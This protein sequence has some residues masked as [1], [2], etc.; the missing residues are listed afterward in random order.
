MYW[1]GLAQDRDTWR[2]LV[3][4]AKRFQG[5][6]NA[7]FSSLPL[8]LSTSQE[9]LCSMTTLI[10][11]FSTDSLYLQQMSQTLQRYIIVQAVTVITGTR[12]VSF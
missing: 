1:I 11:W 9:G 2:G 6:L 5:Q 12:N 8:D 10:R 3:N 7:D 4:G